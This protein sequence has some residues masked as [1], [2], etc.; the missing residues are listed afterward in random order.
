MPI[1]T[2]VRIVYQYAGAFHESSRQRFKVLDTMIPLYYARIASLIN[3]VKDKNA[4]EAEDHFES[5]A[6][7][8]ETLKDYMIEIWKRKGGA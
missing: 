7:T 6:K 3:K 2:W 4:K 1:E 5:Q 8:F